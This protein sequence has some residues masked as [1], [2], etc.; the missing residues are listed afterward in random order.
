VHLVAEDDA[1]GVAAWQGRRVARGRFRRDVRAVA[2]AV[3]LAGA[4]ARRSG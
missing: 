3:G 4:R 2:Q 1:V